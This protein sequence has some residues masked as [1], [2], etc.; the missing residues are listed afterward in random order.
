MANCYLLNFQR[1]CAAP[2]SHNIAESPLHFNREE[3]HLDKRQARKHM[4]FRVVKNGG[5]SITQFPNT[6]L[7]NL[8]T[9]PEGPAEI[10]K[11]EVR[12]VVVNGDRRILAGEASKKVCRNPRSWAKF[13]S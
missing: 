12:R 1:S 2:R 7:L 4:H 11:I 9:W 10:E 8:L 3:G 5:S 6:H 13:D